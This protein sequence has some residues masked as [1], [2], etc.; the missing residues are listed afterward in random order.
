MSLA[1][2]CV[3]F[4]S[5]LS[6][7]CEAACSQ[8]S[9]AQTDLTSLTSIVPRY[10]AIVSYRRNKYLMVCLSFI[11]IKSNPLVLSKVTG[12]ILDDYAVHISI[13]NIQYYIKMARA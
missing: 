5:S 3:K 1:K 10:S 2:V 12:M 8:P 7:I 4:W 11:Y 6:Q 13:N 9:Y